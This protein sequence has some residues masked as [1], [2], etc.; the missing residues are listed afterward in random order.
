MVVLLDHHSTVLAVLDCE[1]YEIGSCRPTRCDV[2]DI[3]A[4]VATS[5]SRIRNQ[6]NGILDPDS[7]SDGKRGSGNVGDFQIRNQASRVTPI[8]HSPSN[9]AVRGDSVHYGGRVS[10]DRE[11]YSVSPR[12]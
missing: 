2:A 11:A 6:R 5:H 1:A 4:V 7:S 3:D 9:Q 10:P 12:G 8:V